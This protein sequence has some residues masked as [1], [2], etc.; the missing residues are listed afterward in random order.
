MYS[1]VDIAGHQYR[2]T[3]GTLID[4][5]KLAYDV[6]AFIELDKVLYIGGEGE[7][8]HI[9]GSPIVQGAKVK[10][11]VI[12]QARDK[13]ILMVKRK[14]RVSERKKGHRQ[15]YTCLLITEIHNGR[16]NSSVL[17]SDSKEA[18]KYLA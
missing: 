17:D 7:S 14:Q 9:I 4:V 6:G 8:S 15:S 12:R 11:K 2:V 16:G 18:K 5:E 13:K 3:A 1:V 10:A